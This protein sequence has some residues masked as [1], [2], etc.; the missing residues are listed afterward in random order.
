VLYAKEDVLPFSP[1]NWHD[2]IVGI[3]FGR[4]I[5]RAPIGFFDNG[6]V[7]SRRRSSSGTAGVAWRRGRTPFARVIPSRTIERAGWRRSS[8]TQFS[9][10]DKAAVV[11]F[12][13]HT[14]LPRDDC[15]YVFRVPSRT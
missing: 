11:G 4:N 8:A 6:R 10:E 15:L 1:I 13:Q 3:R 7:A 5:F 12:H 2:H 9:T 14:L